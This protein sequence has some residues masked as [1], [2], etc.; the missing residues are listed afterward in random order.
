MPAI[1]YLLTEYKNCR[2]E[3]YSDEE[4]FLKKAIPQDARINHIGSTAI[5]KV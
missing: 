5:G 2:K 4:I 3:W 1:S